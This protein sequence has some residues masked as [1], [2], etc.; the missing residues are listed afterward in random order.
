M[1]GF[2][3][4]DIT[5]DRRFYDFAIVI[6]RFAGLDRGDINDDY[7]CNL[8]DVITLW[9]MVDDNRPWPT[10]RHCAGVT[11]DG[12]ISNAAVALPVGE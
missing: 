7:V 3:A 5:D 4:A 10:F 6:S 12:A 11:A 1:S 2:A 8:A 9:N